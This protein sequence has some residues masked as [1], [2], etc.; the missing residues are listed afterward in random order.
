AEL[1]F[2]RVEVVNNTD[3]QFTNV[4]DVNG[5]GKP[6]I[7]AFGDG[8]DGFLS[9]YEYPGF[10][11]HIV[12]RG[13]FNPGRPLAADIDKDGDM[14]FV[15]AKESDRH[16]YWYENPSPKGNPATNL[17]K[18]HHVG[19]TKD[20]KK[21]DYI[22]DYGVAD[23]DGD[24]RMDIVVCTFDSPADVFL[25]FQDGPD[26]WQKKVHTYQNGHEG[27]DI[28]DIDGDGDPDIVTN[29]RWFE[30][31]ANPRKA[32]L[33]EHN[34]DDKW[35]NQSGGWQRNATMIRVADIDGNGRLDVVIS[36][37]EMENYPLSWYSATDPKG[38]WTEHKIDPSYGWCQTL[39]VG[40]VDGD[41]DLDVLAGRF[42]RPTPPDV[43]PPHDI[44]IYFNPGK[45][46][47]DWTKQIVPSDGG[48]YFGHLADIGNDGDLDIVGPRTYFTGPIRIFVNQARSK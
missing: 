11:H 46:R 41:G 7:V 36:H 42:T 24:G 45:G 34:I 37:S 25:Y 26:S 31:P 28:G 19:S 10:Q 17:W 44:R 18:E 8:K 20:A 12:Q 27:L 16:I 13:N 15:V 47:G 2:Q 38:K 23:L 9:W 43:P 30:T 22:K 33:I 40:D 21:G 4:A 32:D 39:D 5:D 14:D 3:S 48:I 29:G 6:D 1:V 35:H